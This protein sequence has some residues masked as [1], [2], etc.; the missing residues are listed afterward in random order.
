MN[1]YYSSKMEENKLLIQ[2]TVNE[3]KTLI[4]NTITNK[5]DSIGDNQKNESEDEIIDVTQ[6]CNLLCYSR[7]TIYALVEKREIPYYKIGRKILFSKNELIEWLKSG[8]RKTKKELQQEAEDYLI[9][10]K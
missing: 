8:R 6:A 9:K 1:K 5:L 4:E 7:P 2:L 3:L 10:N